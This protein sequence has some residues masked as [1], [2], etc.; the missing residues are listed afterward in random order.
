MSDN[1]NAGCGLWALLA[2]IVSA[3]FATSSNQITTTSPTATLI[4]TIAP[5]FVATVYPQETDT[6]FVM[7][8]N[9]ITYSYAPNLGMP[10][11]YEMVGRVLDLNGQPFTD[12]VVNIAGILVEGAPPE[13]GYAFPYE[14]G[15]WGSLLPASPVEY[16]VWLTTEI[17]GEELSPHIT[18]LPRACDQN[19]ARIDFVQVRPLP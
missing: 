6:Y 7:E 16:E 1:K 8:N 18:I 12:Y 15:G 17:D 11:Y 10:C 5:T 4:P 13:H 2:I 19:Q 3:F 14:G 9:E